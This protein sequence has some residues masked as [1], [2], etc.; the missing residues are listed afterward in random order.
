MCFFSINSNQ[1]ID[2]LAALTRFP[3]LK[4]LRLLYCFDERPS[5]ARATRSLHLYPHIKYDTA[6]THRAFQYLLKHKVGTEFEKLEAA[7]GDFQKDDLRPRRRNTVVTYE[8][9]PPVSFTCK[10]DVQDHVLGKTAYAESDYRDDHEF[11]YYFSDSSLNSSRRGRVYL[12]EF[13][14]TN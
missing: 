13:I 9:R 7:L 4:Y 8:D 14:G 3:A 12:E 6:T 1:P 5:F 11:K 2:L 10:I